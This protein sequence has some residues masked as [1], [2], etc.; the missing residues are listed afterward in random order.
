[1]LLMNIHIFLSFE[2]PEQHKMLNEDCKIR[3]YFEEQTERLNLIAPF[4]KKGCRPF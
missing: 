4:Q 2:L 3:L 1:M